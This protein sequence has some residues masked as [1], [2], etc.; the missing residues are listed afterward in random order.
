MRSLA[1]TLIV[2]LAAVGAASA[3]PATE[4]YVPIGQ[5]PGEGTVQGRAGAVVEPAGDGPP[6]IS[7]LGPGD[8]ALGAY[9]ITPATR[10]Y[11][12]RSGEGL[13]N[14]V[15]A[16]EDVRPGNVVEVRVRNDETRAAEWIK[17]R[18]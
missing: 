6:I 12:D 3:H 1:L 14:L 5:S 15:G 11:I 4:Q 13:P 7:V 16:I 17:V 9:V 8:A 2:S 18:P 10:V